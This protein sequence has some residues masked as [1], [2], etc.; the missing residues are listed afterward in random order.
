MGKVRELVSMRKMLGPVFIY[1]G[2]DYV[3]VVSREMR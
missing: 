1:E 2:M 3:K